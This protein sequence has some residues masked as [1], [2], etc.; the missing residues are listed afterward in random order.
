MANTYFQFKQFRID[1]RLAGMKVTTDAC[2]FGSSFDPKP[3]SRILDIGTG[4]GLLTLMSAQRSDSIIDAIEINQDAFGQAK[5]NIN[6]SPWSKQINLIHTSLQHFES[7]RLFDQIICNPPFFV[8]SFKGSSKNKNQALHAHSLSMEDLA[9]N[10]ERLLSPNGEFWVMY[11]EKEMGLFIPI[12]SKYKLYP[13]S[14]IT[15]RNTQDGPVFRNIITFQKVQ[16]N[17]KN[18]ADV[19]I[20]D[21]DGSYSKA[22]INGLK[23][24]YLHL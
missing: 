20:K 9:S 12:A 16:G 2:F 5:D 8:N 4:T 6:N 10:V 15:L 18:V 17:L 11:P 14:Q 19:Y 21:F 22:F 7:E 23:D 24:F 13:S 3:N 1:Q